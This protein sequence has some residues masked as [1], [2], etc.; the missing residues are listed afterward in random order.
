MATDPSNAR[1]VC[2]VTI[3]G[4]GFEQRPTPDVPMSGYADMLHARLSAALNGG[5]APPLLS[6][7]PRTQRPRRDAAS[8]HAGPVYVESSWPVDTDNREAGL[9]RLGVWSGQLEARL[10]GRAAVSEEARLAE[11]GLPIAHVALV[12]SHLQDEGPR[13]VAAVETLARAAI[14][15]GNYEPAFDAIHMAIA[16]TAAAL[17]PPPAHEA[18]AIPPSLRVRGDVRHR[19][20]RLGKRPAPIPE[21]EPPPSAHSGDI[22][23]Q[24]QDD[25]ATY[26]CHNDLR[27]RVRGFVRDALLRLIYREDVAGLVINAHSQGTVVAFD[28]LSQLSPFEARKIWWLVTMGSPLRKYV[29]LFNWEREIGALRQIGL[30]GASGRNAASQRV[31]PLRWTNYWDPRDP[32]ADPLRPATRKGQ[33]PATFTDDE[34]LYRWVDPASGAI[35]P[36]AIED[37]QV[38]N[39]THSFG[40]LRAHNYWDNQL[41]VIEP[42]AARLRAIVRD[43]LRVGERQP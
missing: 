2:L 27:E 31:L 42:L 28:V 12:Y 43:R 3:H 25:V 17:E 35:S 14:S 11:P 15:L 6:D 7:D 29:D 18:E 34:T 4:I 5:D 19:L 9:K 10:A 8:G 39:V 30:R 21:I 40:S 33:P 41:Q 24:L 20:P 32:V 23:L 26:I 22:L 37:R 1:C 13:V 38:D 16:D 36:I